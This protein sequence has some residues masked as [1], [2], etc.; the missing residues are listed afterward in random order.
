M[1][2]PT[3]TTDLIDKLSNS[4]DPSIRYTCRL[5]LQ[6]AELGGLQEEIRNSERVKALLSER[7]GDGRIPYHPYSKWYGAHWALSLLAELDYPSGDDSLL[8]M[9]DQVYEWLFSKEHQDQIVSIRGLTRRC[10]SME[11]N[12]LFYSLKL[13]LVDDN[14]EELADNLKKW[15]WPDGGWN[16]DRKPSAKT[17][18]FTESFIPMRALALHADLTKSQSSRD[19]VGL[20]AELFLRRRLIWSERTGKVIKPTWEKLSFPYF[21][22]YGL[23]SALKVMAEAGFVTDPRCKN[24]LDLLESKRLADGS[25]PGERHFYHTTGDRQKKRICL[26]DWG[27]KTCPINEWV[28]VEALSILNAA[29]RLN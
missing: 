6:D 4:A 26:T 12:A 11:G 5:Y 21:H 8:P 9:R 29:G 3:H 19:A 28:T 2:D 27:R 7:G 10:A 22:N 25:F 24:A 18:S 16:C 17:S 1:H 20:A 23:L 15:Q 13:G 14:T